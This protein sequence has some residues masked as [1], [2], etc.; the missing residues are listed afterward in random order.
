MQNLKSQQAGNMFKLIYIFIL[1]L[2]PINVQALT[3]K[4]GETLSSTIDNENA[5][6]AVL[7]LDK[8]VERPDLNFDLQT[9][10]D[11]HL[12]E[13][14]NL[15]DAI[16]F[17][18]RVG[19]GAPVD[20]FMR[21]VGM[22][23]REAIALVVKE[24]RAHQD[25]FEISDWYHNGGRFGFYTANRSP[26]QTCKTKTHRASLEVNWS[27]SLLSNNIPQ[28]ERLALLW[29][30][31]FSV[32]FDDIEYP[33]AFADHIQSIRANAAGNF[34][35]L[36]RASLVDPAIILYLSNNVSLKGAPNENLARE[37]LE[38]FSLGEGKYNE[39][40]IQYFAT[41]LTGNGV[42]YITEK[43][44]YYPDKVPQEQRVAFGYKYEDLDEFF[45]LL[46]NHPSFGEFIALKFYS[47][48][49]SIEEPKQ[50]DI[51]FMVSRFRQGNFD[52]T[53]LFE[54]TISL[55][56]FWSED[57]RLTLIKSPVDVIYG[58]ARTLN[59]IR[60]KGNH[61]HLI[62]AIENLG[63]SLFNPPNIA[64]WP[65]GRS[66]L[67][68]QMI[69]NR[70]DELEF[71]FGKL[72]EAKQRQPV[73]NAND[74]IRDYI[75]GLDEF[76]A[77]AMRDQML[78]ETMKLVYASGGF[79]VAPQGNLE[80]R[81]LNV[82]LNEK[83]YNGLSILVGYD[84]EEIYVRVTEGLSYPAL[85]E[86]FINSNYDDMFGTRGANIYL[87]GGPKRMSLSSEDKDVQLTILRLF[88]SM[89]ILL[90]D[91]KEK[92]FEKNPDIKT[93]MSRALNLVSKKYHI[94]ASHEQPAA[95]YASGA[96]KPIKWIE[97]SYL[98]EPR[99][100]NFSIIK[101]GRMPDDYFDYTNTLKIIHNN[102]IKISELLLPD[103][104]LPTNNPSEIL[105]F[106]GYQLK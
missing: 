61:G 22:T 96:I 10:D 105:S 3:I 59:S 4:S 29:L 26:N 52:I 27:K 76:Y 97:G 12:E 35:D 6:I 66:W 8:P 18:N 33:H 21:Y 102:G 44:H 64:G 57:N 100:I 15:K 65:S 20:R 91:N 28:F 14:M 39:K 37:F 19:I 38:L 51:A 94:L 53:A 30:D 42:N 41:L 77:E 47:E 25:P 60:H 92:S 75:S 78:F 50:E 40:D 63:Q 70:I 86:R 67:T 104:D 36:L 16:R 45:D 62:K 34:E 43:Y 1:L 9:F 79:G 11:G 17:E 74:V 84:Q 98:C 58:T 89:N 31:H 69:E 83:F 13:V 68:G 32:A 93:W 23:R 106:E 71:L 103:L 90:K 56:H 73:K 72:E 48:F 7:A 81:F 49:I 2:L 95:Q 99:K 88:Q 24:L 55:E 5:I 87:L 82:K 80:L 46:T 101:D 85:T 54:A